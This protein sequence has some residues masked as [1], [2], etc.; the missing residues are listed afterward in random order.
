MTLEALAFA[1]LSLATVVVGQGV[2]SNAVTAY[3]P[4]IGACPKGFELV[5]S[6]G[7][8]GNQSLGQEEA[9][10]I[11]ERKA[12]VLPDAW[13]TYLQNVQSKNLD[14]PGYV[15]NILG[16]EAQTLPIFHPWASRSAAGALGLQFSA[17]ES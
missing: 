6:A 16:G 4:S 17:R 14:L 7:T 3:T 2:D 8:V 15:S 1:V 13:K 11:S 5:R 10:Y 9:S 12:Q